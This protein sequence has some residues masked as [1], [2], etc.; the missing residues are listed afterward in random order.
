[1]KIAKKVTKIHVFGKIAFWGE[2]MHST[3]KQ[4]LFQKLGAFY[5]TDE[6]IKFSKLFS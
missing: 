1:M 3:Q 5:K 2:T 4:T 6:K